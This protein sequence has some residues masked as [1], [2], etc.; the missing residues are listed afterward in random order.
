MPQCFLKEIS[1]YMT[2]KMEQKSI[3]VLHESMKTAMSTVS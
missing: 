2:G 1:Q 3:S